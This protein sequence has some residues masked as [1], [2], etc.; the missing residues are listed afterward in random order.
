MAEETRQR[1]IAA[2]NELFRR[3]GYNGAGLSEISR[4]SGAT[5]GSI[6]H[7]FPGGK[8][9]LTQHVLTETGDAYRELF[10]MI[11][12]AEDSLAD[13]ML[14]FFDGA[15]EVLEGD[16]FIDPC[17][18]GT[19]AREVA[20]TDDE[21]RNAASQVFAGWVDALTERLTDGQA[22]TD[23]ARTT[24]T[25]VIAMIEGGFILSRTHRDADLMRRMG[26]QAALLVTAAS[27]AR[28]QTGR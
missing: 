12:D 15:A 25:A 21:V 6:Y 17:P 11:L 10:E 27:Q 4:T 8:S 5:T 14:A 20:S 23:E 9:E 24:A 1:I 28:Q 2:T 18:I 19:V 22:P 26:S 13:G 3:V 7:F 16:D